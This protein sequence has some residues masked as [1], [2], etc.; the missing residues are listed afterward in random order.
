M[1]AVAAMLLLGLLGC[2]EETQDPPDLALVDAGDAVVRD[3]TQVKDLGPD[4]PVPPDMAPDGPPPDMLLPDM[5]PDAAPCEPQGPEVCNGLDDDCSGVIDDGLTCGPWVVANCTLGIGYAEPGEI[6]EDGSPRWGECPIV[7]APD[8]FQRPCN[9]TQGESRFRPIF[10]DDHLREGEALGLFFAC[11]ASEVGQW[12]ENFCQVFLGHST[13]EE[14]EVQEAWGTCPTTLGEDGPRRC[15]SSDSDGRYHS[16]TFPGLV[17]H[18]DTMGVAFVCA[19]RLDPR[20]AQAVQ[21]SVEVFLGWG[22]GRSEVANSDGAESWAGCPARQRLDTGDMRC[23][24][25]NGDGL[26]HSLPLKD[27]TEGRAHAFA[28]MLRAT[29]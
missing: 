24:G 15:T 13:A 19:D 9:Q 29:E 8:H 12:V 6:P 3:A 17:D 16:L 14:P 25:T 7:A 11:D 20:R 2:S 18:D 1:R 22:F 10:V 5:A 26:F 27:V 28:V 21:E 4:A 23:V